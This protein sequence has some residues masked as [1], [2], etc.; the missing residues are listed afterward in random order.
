MV[1]LWAMIILWALAVVAILLF[2]A[3]CQCLS[4]PEAQTGALPEAAE[5]VRGETTHGRQATS[6]RTQRYGSVRDTT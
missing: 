2:L 6:S 5:P 3:G 1:A 4:T